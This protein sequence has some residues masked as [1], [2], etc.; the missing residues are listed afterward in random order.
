MTKMAKINTYTTA[1]KSYP[2][3]YPP[4]FQPPKYHGDEYIFS[5]FISQVIKTKNR[6]RS[7]N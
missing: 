1:K 3:E 4:G 2:L 6:N 7:I 5:V